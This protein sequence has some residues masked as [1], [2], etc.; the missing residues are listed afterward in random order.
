MPREKA[1]EYARRN[2]ANYPERYIALC[3]VGM[4]KR[5]KGMERHHWSY[6]P[7]HYKDVIYL[8]SKDHKKLHRFMV[9][10]KQIF[11]FRKLDGEILDTKE[12][13]LNYFESIKDLP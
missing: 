13:H 5:I 12:K 3:K 1:R 9:Y 4:V 8:A 6:N 10:D 11:Y 2:K 7:E